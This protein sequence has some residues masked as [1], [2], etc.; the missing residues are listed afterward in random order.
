[1]GKKI[2]LGNEAIAYAILASGTSVA[3]SYPGTPA[4]EI[5]ETVMDLSRQQNLQIHVEWSINEKT[6]FEIA[7]TNSISGRRSAVSMKQVGLNVALDPVMSAAYMGV[8]GGLVIIVADDPGPHS[9]QTEQDSRFFS[10]L[11]KIP[12]LDPSSPQEA[13]KMASYAFELSEKHKTP[14]ILRPTTRV[15]H[16]RQVVD[17]PEITSSKIT[18][19]FEKDPYRWAATPGPRLKL[20]KELSQKIETIQAEEIAKPKI[21]FGKKG[22]RL[23]ILTSG[24][25]YA[26]VKDIHRNIDRWKDFALYKI[27]MPYPLNPDELRKITQ[28]HEKILVIEETEPVIEMQFPCRDRV[29]GRLDN[30]IP[31]AGEL[32][33]DIIMRVIDE[34]LGLEPQTQKDAPKKQRAPSLC[35]GCAHRA[36]FFAMKKAFPKGIFTS[37]IGCYTLGLNLGA[38]DT[39]LCMGAAV[40]QAAGFYHAFKREKNPPPVIAS[41]GDSTFFHAGIPPTINAIVTG[42]RFVLVV[43]DNAL[44]AMTGRQPTPA[45]D[46]VTNDFSGRSLQLERILKGCGIET[47]FIHDPYDIAGFIKI[48]KN[49]HKK[50]E[51]EGVVAVIARHPCIKDKQKSKNQKTYSIQITDDCNHCGYCI[52]NF[53]CPA[54]IMEENTVAI[55]R[56]L[57]IGCGVC[58]HACPRDAIVAKELPEKI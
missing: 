55:D 45:T 33:P 2:L 30:S 42:A 41:I 50:T 19:H 14:V 7:F 25:A 20:H 35:A 5:L 57:C 58:I 18:P 36:A 34:A 44:T 13:L 10:M 37:D 54:L 38:V 31:N 3:T 8:T 4:S 24:I 26:Y 15:C 27:D 49:A 51:P 29:S 28:D 22:S 21:V 39:C 9:S 12:V 52:K 11:A 46:G 23:A 47:V 43:L 53:E 32:T 16:A 40:S 48:I 56:T 17:L 6:A 1:M